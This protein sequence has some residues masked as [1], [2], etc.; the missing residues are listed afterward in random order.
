MNFF[1]PSF[2]DDAPNKFYRTELKFLSLTNG[3][4]CDCSF[5]LYFIYPCNDIF[6]WISVSYHLQHCTL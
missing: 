1:I 5:P 3:R 6:W 2:Y 4:R